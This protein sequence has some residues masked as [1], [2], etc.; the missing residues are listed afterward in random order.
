VIT[1]AEALAEVLRLAGER[2]AGVERVPLSTCVGRIAAMD[3]T[4]VAPIPSF[5]NSS[6][7]GFA[8]SA[9]ATAQASAAHPLKLTVVGCVVAGD[10]AFREVSAPL[11]AVEI[12]TGAPLPG[13]ALDAVAKVEDLT[14]TRDGSGRPLEI[15]V[16]RAYAH[17]ENIR[18]RGADFSPG[19][20][21]VRAGT[22][23]GP[24][25]VL[26]LAAVGVTEIQVNRVPRVGLISTGKELVDAST[27]QLKPG[28]IRNATS[29]FLLAALPLFGAQAEL[30][31]KVPDEPQRFIDRLGELLDRPPASRPDVIL[32][33]GAVSMGRHDFIPDA[34][35]KLGASI[36]FHRVAVQ[37]GR[38][39]LVAEWSRRDGQPSPVFFG[40]PGNPISTAV[41][42]RFFVTPFL[43]AVTGL[44]PER[45]VHLPLAKEATKTAGLRCFFKARA[46]LERGRGEVTVLPGQASF[47]VSPLLEANAWAVLPEEPASV[48]AG[49]EVEVFPQQPDA[50]VF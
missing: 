12:M 39:I 36:R 50:F 42:L 15:E 30:A 47:M 25:Q 8:I 26:G 9:A 21:V 35:R 7:D 18:H 31:A 33:T 3:V 46:V 45:P 27:A 17:G 38:P 23:L 44:A 22:R 16:R 5:D 1:Y 48:A 32:S 6:M 19:Q 13:G 10:P 29:P 24:E 20:V 41:G 28:M 4:G 43:R 11:E 14:V 37:P 49:T 34:L 2:L 40:I